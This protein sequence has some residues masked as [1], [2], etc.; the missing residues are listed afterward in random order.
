MVLVGKVNREI[1][2]AINVHGP[3]AV[4]VSGEDTSLLSAKQVSPDLGFVGEVTDVNTDIV[5]RLMG[6]ELIP[7]IATIGVDA[8]GQAYNINADTAAAA[9]AGALGAEKLVY[10]TDIEG[11]RRDVGDAGVAA[12]VRCRSRRS[13]RSSPTAPSAAA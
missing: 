13:T 3:L 7:V 4:G 11:I 2:A 10:L 5:T 12:V 6:E 1:V 9:I 8:D